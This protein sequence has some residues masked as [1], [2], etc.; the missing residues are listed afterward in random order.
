[1]IFPCTVSGVGHF[2]NW[3]ATP[4]SIRNFSMTFGGACTDAVSYDAHLLINQS[5]GSSAQDGATV[6][7]DFAGNA[8]YTN[9][10]CQAPIVPLQA[11]L[12]ASTG[13]SSVCP[14]TAITVSAVITS[15]NYSSFF[16]LNGHG[17]YGNTTSLSTSYLTNATYT[18]IDALVFAIITNCN[19]TVY[20]T[21]NIPIV[22]S[23]PVAITANGP[24]TFCSGGSVVLTANGSGTFL[25]SN[26]AT[27]S[28]ITATTS[29]TYT[30][31]ATSSC[32]ISN[33]SQL[34]TVNTITPAAI[35]ASGPTTFCTGD[36][37]TLS[38]S[39][40]GT[41]LWS[42]GATTNTITVFT[43]N[44]YTLTITETCG[45][46]SASQLVTVTTGTPVTITAS[47]PTTLCAGDSVT[48]TA[49]GGGP[50]L[51][52][53]GATTN[54]ITVFTTNNYI[55]TATN[56]CGVTN[57]AQQVT[58][59][60]APVAVINANGPTTFCIGDSVK[61]TAG[62]G[63]T[64]LWSNGAT[65][66]F[67]NVNTTNT[68][69]VT[70]TAVCG[71]S[72]A[73]QAIVV[74]TIPVTVISANGPTTFCQGTTLT[75]TASGASNYLWSNGATT[76]SITV[77]QSGNYTVTGTNNCGSSTDATVISVNPLPLAV[78]TPAG[79]ITSFCTGG[80]LSLQASGGTSYLWSNGNNSNTITVTT[81]GTYTVTVTNSCG[82]STASQLT[83]ETSTPVTTLSANSTVL[84]PGENILLTATGTAAT[85]LWSTGET[86][87]T[88]TVS[89]AGIY[90]VTSTNS[91]GNDHD[92]I[93][94]TS[95]NL[96][97]NFIADT[98][99]RFCTTYCT[100]YEYQFICKYL[101]LGFWGWAIFNRYQSCSY[102]PE[103]R[104]LHRHTY[105]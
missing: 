62:G 87:N 5:G 103:R 91:C 28:S 25:W 31:T 101:S 1:M 54:S 64:F 13:S 89:N 44:T 55:V 56:G 61:L 73:S 72:T 100:F 76:P 96:L 24:T 104:D 65:T 6:V 23:A 57:S 93:V 11:T 85:Y 82:S 74:N 105:C 17:T 67:I 12:T 99:F 95:S 21:L 38:T 40:S 97:A 92:T 14:G 37:V 75:L 9:T 49:N 53:N 79:G 98:T 60:P 70:V 83:T 80:S 68:Y 71:S 34:V 35:T 33:A 90:N 77:T 48:L 15:G 69:T 8:T 19:D 10:G 22:S 7:Y 84:C 18:G 26:G 52:S 78:I 42:N 81:G 66:S 51:W 86:G 32:G 2:G 43:S 36:S 102:L 46:S 16:W 41:Y 45:T 50:Y 59:T 88:I 27:T 63:T 47:G 20:D 94:I 30:V 4:N 39:I 58:F 29:N 3:N